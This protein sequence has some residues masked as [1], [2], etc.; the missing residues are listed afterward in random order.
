MNAITEPASTV[1]G[2]T[3]AHGIAATA[4]GGAP[5]SAWLRMRV[6]NVSA[7]ESVENS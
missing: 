6:G 3:V 2:P 7:R 1:S 4:G 5:L